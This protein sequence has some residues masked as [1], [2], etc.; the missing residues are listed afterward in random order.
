MRLSYDFEISGNVKDLAGSMYTVTKTVPPDF[1]ATE[2]N[3]DAAA[4]A[5]NPL[6]AE[7]A[8]RTISMS[9]DAR[10]SRSPSAAAAGGGGR[11][12]Q[13]TTAACAGV[14]GLRFERMA[15]EDERT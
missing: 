8:L 7:L 11:R 14:G 10:A 15:T 6:L 1:I 4:L 13:L 3:F 2:V 9:I 5:F 12:H